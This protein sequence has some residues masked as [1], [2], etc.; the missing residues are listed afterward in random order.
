MTIMNTFYKEQIRH[1]INIPRAQRV[2]LAPGVGGGI[3]VAS[4]GMPMGSLQGHI[5]ETMQ[6][7]ERRRYFLLLNFNRKYSPDIGRKT[8]PQ[9][10]EPLVAW[11]E[12]ELLRVLRTQGGRLLKDRESGTRPKGAG[13]PQAE[14]EL[15]ALAK[16]I[17]RLEAMDHELSFGS[18]LLQ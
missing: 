7:Q 4:V 15:K 6:P 14:E 1:L 3:M 10:L 17:E 9:A 5:S 18:L 8:I 16:Q 12:R 13:L 11:L 2:S